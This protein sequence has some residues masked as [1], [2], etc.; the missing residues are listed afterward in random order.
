MYANLPLKFCLKVSYRC[1]GRCRYPTKPVGKSSSRRGR[2]WATPLC[3]D[4][5]AGNSPVV[6]LDVIQIKH[7][8][9]LLKGVSSRNP[10]V[11][12]TEPL[13]SVPLVPNERNETRTCRTLAASVAEGCWQAD[14]V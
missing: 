8:Q 4:R 1:S 2:R 5:H 3:Y 13:A 7:H 6:S 11:E 14:R 9:K 10:V 12:V